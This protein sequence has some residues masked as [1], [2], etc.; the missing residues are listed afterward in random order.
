MLSL[1]TNNFLRGR[2]VLW[3]TETSK[4]GPNDASG[5]VGA[6]FLQVSTTS[7]LLLRGVHKAQPVPQLHENP[8]INPGVFATRANR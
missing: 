6:H 7:P 4:T 8:R 3:K 1:G 2:G 5:V